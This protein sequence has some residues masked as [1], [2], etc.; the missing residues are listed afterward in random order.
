MAGLHTD[1]RSKGWKATCVSSVG[2]VPI[3]LLFKG[4]V[5]VSGDGGDS[6]GGLKRKPLRDGFVLVSV[7]LAS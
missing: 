7:C 3:K 1:S 5:S 2:S 4:S 6:L